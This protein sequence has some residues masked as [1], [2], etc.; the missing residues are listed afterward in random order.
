MKN[1]IALVVML[2]LILTACGPAP[3][4]VNPTE[5]VPTPQ[6]DETVAPVEEFTLGM[7]LVGPINDGG[8]S[9]AHYEAGRYVEEVVEN[10]T[11][12]YVDRV[13]PA[14]RPNVTIPQVVDE[15]VNQGADLIITNS[16]DFQDGTNEA[17]LNHPDV[18]FVHIS[19]DA[20]L[21]GTAPENLRNLMAQMEYGKMITGCAAAL[22]TESGDIAYLGPLVNAETRRLVNA[23]YLGAKYCWETYRE[24]PVEELTFKVTWIGFWFNIPGVTLDPT[25]VAGD[26][27]A[28]GRDIIISGIDTT[29]GIVEANKATQGGM[30]VLAAPYDHDTAC[31]I[32]PDVCI[33][34]PYFNW[35]ADYVELVN[36]VRADQWVS[37][38]EFV[39]PDW[40]NL[41]DK[42]KSPIGYLVGDATSETSEAALNLFIK[43]LSN[44]AVNLYTGPLNFQDGT[45]FLAESQTATVK[46]VWYTPQLLEGIDG[47]SGQ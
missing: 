19:G 10:V 47:Q 13:N 45:V 20:V 11:F 28:E 33:G 26:F 22:A 23:A 6:A 39:A 44:G 5:S 14:D 3:V 15:L 27:I 18:K 16:A 34:V 2:T 40:Q 24:L 25:K 7:V 42:T 35:G 36:M 32:A 46:D 43:D 12:I 8:W 37:E 31:E 38:W 4:A 41:N 21:A 17:A 9:Q 1:L 30:R 29:E